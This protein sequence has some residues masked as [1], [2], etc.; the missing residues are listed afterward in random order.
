MRHQKSS[1]ISIPDFRNKKILEINYPQGRA[2]GVFRWFRFDLK[3]SKT[4][5]S[6][7]HPRIRKYDGFIETPEKNPEEF[8]RLN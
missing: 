2:I 4:E 5:I 6:Y 8:F 1:G 7:L 3:R